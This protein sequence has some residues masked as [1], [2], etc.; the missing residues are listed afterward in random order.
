[1]TQRRPARLLTP[2]QR[3]ELTRELAAAYTA[4]ASTTELAHGR[5]FSQTFAHKLL[6]EAGVIVS[7]RRH[8][9]RWGGR[10]LF[11]TPARRAA[12]AAQL[13]TD[14]NA[15]ASTPELV[16]AYQLSYGHVRQLLAEAGVTMR[17]LGH[18]RTKPAPDLT[19]LTNRRPAPERRS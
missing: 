15:G 6:R 4:G 17:P 16:A 13:A 14:Y 12:L 5:P 8:R 9:M 10:C 3:A 11:L 1:M 7:P 18:R 19:D 2:D